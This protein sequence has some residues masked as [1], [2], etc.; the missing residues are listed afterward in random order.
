[1]DLAAV[2]A[3]RKIGPAVAARIL[4]LN[5]N[6]REGYRV[7]GCHPRPSIRKSWHIDVCTRERFERKW[8]KGS[9]RR[10]HPAQRVNAGG[11][12]RWISGCAM[13]QGPLLDG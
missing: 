7:R 6:Y 4:R 5:P 12:R 10:I 1:M 2:L 3:E 13:M 11:K 8:G 9:A